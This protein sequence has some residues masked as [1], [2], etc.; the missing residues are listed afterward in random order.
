M[1]AFCESDET[2]LPPVSPGPIAQIQGCLCDDVSTELWLSCPAQFRQTMLAVITEF[3]MLDDWTVRSTLDRGDGVLWPL[4][5]LD[6]YAVTM[7]VRN[8]R[9]R[10]NA[11]CDA[12]KEC[13]LGSENAGKRTTYHRLELM[14]TW[15]TSMLHPSCLQCRL[16]SIRHSSEPK[17]EREDLSRWHSE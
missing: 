14:D 15:W 16:H 10:P 12:L 17:P 6:F 9:S 3:S 8:L 13:Q 11:N 2:A 5:V 4:G 1:F 7:G